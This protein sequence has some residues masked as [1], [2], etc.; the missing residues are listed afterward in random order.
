MLNVP[1]Y[2]D[3]DGI[4]DEDDDD[5][6]DDVVLRVPMTRMV[7]L[8]VGRPRVNMNMAMPIHVANHDVL[9]HGDDGSDGDDGGTTVM[10]SMMA[11]MMMTV[12]LRT[13]MEEIDMSAMLMILCY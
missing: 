3:D 1:A 9:L 2:E 5:D 11:M 12:R 6:G 10:C 7:Q 4:D 8:V 13:R